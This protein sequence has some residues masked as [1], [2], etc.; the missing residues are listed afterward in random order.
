MPVWI[1]GARGETQNETSAGEVPL[2]LT[3]VDESLS[4]LGIGIDP[5]LDGHG[6]VPAETVL[7]SSDEVPDGLRLTKEEAPELLLVCPL[8]SEN[9]TRA[10]E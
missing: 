10:R 1:A 2:S 4:H 8:L 5:D 7:R 9:K 3:S 6:E